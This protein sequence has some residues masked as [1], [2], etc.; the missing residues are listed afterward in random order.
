MLALRI[1]AID[2][3]YR[4]KPLVMSLNL[5]ELEAERMYNTYTDPDDVLLYCKSIVGKDPI[6]VYVDYI[7]CYAKMR[8]E[9][10]ITSYGKALNYALSKIK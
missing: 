8:A 10:G 7:L 2:N 4:K 5:F 9:S 1:W 6:E 3:G